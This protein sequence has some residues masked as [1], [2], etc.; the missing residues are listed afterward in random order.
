MEDIVEEIMGS[1]LDEYDEQ[2]TPDISRIDDSTFIMMGITPLRDVA[3]YFDEHDIEVDLPTED[4]E[5]LGGFLIGQLGHIPEETEKPL[6]TYKGLKFRIVETQ[7]K[8]ITKVIV[9]KE[10]IKSEE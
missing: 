2:E 10:P 6:V 3:E 8:C 4:Y 9:T 7:E 5:T 1:I